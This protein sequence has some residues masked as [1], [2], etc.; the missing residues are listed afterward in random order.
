LVQRDGAD[1][2]KRISSSQ[3]IVSL[4]TEDLIKAWQSAG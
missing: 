2:W 3:Q 1:S 4:T